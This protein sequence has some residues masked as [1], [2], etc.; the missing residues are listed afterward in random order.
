MQIP[1]TLDM[2]A[3]YFNK[4][5]PQY[6][7]FTPNIASKIPNH[8]GAHMLLLSLVVVVLSPFKAWL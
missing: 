3:W 4:L 2:L 8:H 5:C 7:F 1:E 6:C